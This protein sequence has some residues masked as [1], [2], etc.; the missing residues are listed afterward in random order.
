M[1]NKLKSR[2]FEINKDLLT[3][4]PLKEFTTFNIGGPAD[5]VM[6]ASSIQQI[7]ETIKTC[8]EF[9][10]PV[11][12]LGGGSNVLISDSG[13]RGVIIINRFSEWS[14][15]KN[16]LF[17]EKRPKTKARLTTV[18]DQF[19]STDGLE[20][21]DEK[22]DQIRIKT[23]SGMRLIPFIK[24]LFQNKITG[25]QWFSGIPASIGGAIYMNIHGGNYF[26]G[27]FVHSALLFDGRQLKQVDREYFKFDYDWSILHE[28]NEII[29]EAELNLFMG[30]VDQAKDL[31]TNWARRKSLQP[32]KSVGCVF[33]NLTEME[34]EKFNLPTSSIGYLIDKVLGLKGM[35]KGGATISA[36]HAAFIENTGLASSDDVYFLYNMILEKAESQI[37]LKLI[38]EIEFIGDF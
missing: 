31:S 23:S 12:I 7:T 16:D 17:D 11:K 2:L 4:Y 26:F 28:T 32:Q 37:G 21:S 6:V 38:P 27:D 29:L 30:D 14:V 34:Q 19:Y 36:K 33:R 13:Y 18:G 5:F 25:L 8:S 3:N 35:Q 24:T 20:Y 15:L 22:A 9:K 10:I 1:D